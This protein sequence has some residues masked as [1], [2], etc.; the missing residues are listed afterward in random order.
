MG[1]A[2]VKGW[3]ATIV[4]H[5]FF[6]GLFFSLC[7]LFIKIIIII[8]VILGSFI[9]IVKIIVLFQLLNCS[10]LNPWVLFLAPLI[11][12]PSPLQGGARQGLCDTSL[13]CGPKSQPWAA[14][15]KI[16]AAWIW[17]KHFTGVNTVLKSECFCAF[18]CWYCL[19]G[20]SFLQDW[21]TR[22]R[23]HWFTFWRLSF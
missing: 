10:Y 7:V 6:L 9:S 3:R 1:W 12:S 17:N 4:H 14:A 13:P 20:D 21:I 5:L 19:A 18:F 23:V 8:I 2:L 11:L 22:A 15:F 16:I